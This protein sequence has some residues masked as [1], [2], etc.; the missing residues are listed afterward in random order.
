MSLIPL[1]KEKSTI[2]L[3]LAPPGWGKTTLILDVYNNFDG[4][5]VFISPLRALSEEF[6]LRAKNEYKNI[7]KTSEP[8]G[9]SKFLSSKKSMLV[10]TAEK[11]CDSIIESGMKENILY[12][13]D[14]FHLFYY[15]GESFRPLLKEKLMGCANNSCQ[16]LALTATMDR[17]L[18]ERSYDEFS[19]GLEN[20]F[21][22]NLGNQILLNRPNK[23]FNLS[24][25][26]EKFINRLILKDL[27]SSEDLKTTLVFCKYR[28]DVEMWL[29]ICS[30]L[31]VKA[32]GCVG[33]EVDTFLEDLARMKK[34]RCIFTTSALSHGVN[35]PVI[36]KVFLTYQ[37]NNKDFWTQM[38]GRGG[39][40]GSPYTVYEMESVL[41]PLN[42]NKLLLT[43]YYSIQTFVREIFKS[44]LSGP[45]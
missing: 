34:P 30:R 11:L 21:V 18:M 17:N 26:G 1:L 22:L 12:I 38:V 15:W 37:I 23:I 35:L 14:E 16:I 44:L 3:F 13:F 8:E 31:K 24:L 40:D 4:K 5:I 25:L 32:L 7:Y 45:L 42:F 28:K 10:T 6:Y 43:C 41:R 27:L 29:D 36:S 9:G 19:L 2:T 39:R 20:Q 33:G